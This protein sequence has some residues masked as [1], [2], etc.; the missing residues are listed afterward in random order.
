MGRI[1]VAILGAGAMGSTLATPFV[2]AGHDVRLWGTWLDDEII[3]ALRR[4]EPHPGTKARVEPR[5]RLFASDQL[6]QAVDGTDMVLLAVTSEGLDPVFALTVPYLKPTHRVVTVAKGFGRDGAGR[7]ILL[8]DLLRS[9]LTPQLA[10]IPI[11][12]VGGPSKAVEVGQRA[13]TCVTYA[14]DRLEDARECQRLFGTK[15][16]VIEASDDLT[17]LEICAALK[18][19]YAI[20]LGICE[21]FKQREGILHNNM[22]GAVFQV[23]VDEL[24]QVCVAAG[25]RAESARGLPGSGDLE[26]T[27]EAGRNRVLG[28]LIGGGMTADQAVAAMKAKGLTVEGYPATAYGREYCQQLGLDEQALPLLHGMYQILYRGAEP[29]EALLASLHRHYATRP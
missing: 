14:A 10:A 22:K 20:G 9:R 17:G 21:G 23:A 11:I 29:F 6:E 8:P 27:G 26:L 19:V 4:G 7:V 25:G 15:V 13:P 28:E 18:N 5:A 16:Y 12:A 24:A 2:E 3:A 1:A